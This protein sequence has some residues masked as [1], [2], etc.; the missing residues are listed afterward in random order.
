MLVLLLAFPALRAED[1]DKAPTPREQYAA[2]IKEYLQTQQAYFSA[3]RAAKTA[4]ERQKAAEKSPKADKFAAKFLE[5]AEKNAKDPVAVDAML[6]IASNTRANVAKAE[7]AKA[8]GALFQNHI[9][10]DKFSAT[11]FNNVAFGYESQIETF[12]RAVLAKNPDKGV[13]AEASLALAQNLQ[14]KAGLIKRMADDS[15]LA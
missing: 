5:L 14:Q 4:E 13:K 1:K 12:L 11:F 2:L 15:K 10:S 7:R 6:W 9:E 8:L 3:M